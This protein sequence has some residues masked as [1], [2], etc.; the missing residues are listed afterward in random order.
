[1]IDLDADGTPEIL[2]IAE[3]S[4]TS[5]AFK[6]AADGTWAEIGNILNTGCKGIRGGQWDGRVETAPPPLKDVV[7]GGQRLRVN[8]GCASTP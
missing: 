7:V 3:T 2:L 5:A 1:V 4:G 8:E 6:S